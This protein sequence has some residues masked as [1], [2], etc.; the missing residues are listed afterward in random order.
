MSSLADRIR[1]VISTG[2]RATREAG[3]AI[4]D[5]RLPIDGSRP[6]A[7]DARLSTPASID[8]SPLGGSWQSESFVVDRRWNPDA[9]HGRDEIGAMAASLDRCS[10]EAMLF[11][12]GAPQVPFVFF[13]LETTGLNGGA[14]TLAFLVGCG[15]FESDGAFRTRQFL[16]TRY[17]DERR[18]LES[19]AEEFARAGA[20]VSF[21]GKSF[22]AP[23]LETRYLF[24]RLPWAGSGMP[25][26]DVLHPAR[27]FWRRRPLERQPVRGY[28]M[29][30]ELSGR[31]SDSG[32]SLVALERQILGSRRS[33]DVPGFE[34][35]GRYF[36]FVRG[37]DARPLEAVLEHNRLDLLTLAALTARL[38]QLAH[39]GPGAA[40][41]GRE[42]LALARAYARSGR[43]HHAIAALEQAVATCDRSPSGASSAQVKIESL[44]MLAILLRRARHYAD[45]AGCWRRILEM[46]RCPPAIVREATGALA[47]HHEHRERDLMAAK[48]FALLSVEQRPDVAWREA[49][50]HRV[51]RLE[52][53]IA[54][55]ELR[56]ESLKFEA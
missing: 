33:G 47:I 44:R 38:L 31:D 41:D 40:R 36:Q 39:A 6:A 14:G 24:H 3:L 18:L 25:H 9:R 28:S 11:A 52:K 37:G 19:V 49:A 35:P 51:A 10:H 53:K 34:I 17:A 30:T 46:R 26:V 7:P 27:Q 43:D 32:C 29:A 8:L 20:L 45:A 21:N 55:N 23:L 16:L 12:A 42:A 56:L 5:S 50:R 4:P 48:T 13:D 22:D 54:N 15:W 2:N 1:G